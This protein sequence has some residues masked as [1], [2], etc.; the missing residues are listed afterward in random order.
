MPTAVVTGSY[1]LVGSYTA[2]Y[3]SEHGFNVIGIDADI[4]SSL[5]NDVPR[6]TAH[7]KKRI[8]DNKQVHTLEIDLRDFNL[9]ESQL[10]P[11]IDH[12]NGIDLFV[13]C[14][15]QPSHDWASTNPFADFTLNSSVTLNVCEFLRRHSSNSLLIHL[16]TNKVYGDTPNNLPLYEDI[17]RYELPSD[18]YFYNGVDES[19]SID[20]SLHSLFGVS[21][22]CADLYVQEYSRYFGMPALVLRGGCLTG[23]KHRGAKLHGFLNYLV[24]CAS[25][26]QTYTINGYKGKQVRDN[27]HATDIGRLVYVAYLKHVAPVTVNY[28]IVANLGGGRSNSISL[29]EAI[30]LLD[31]S[32]DLKLNYNIS[33]NNRVGDHI[34]YISD[35][36]QLTK[37]YDWRPKISINQIFEEII[38]DSR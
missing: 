36:S 13:H 38:N 4:R 7:E 32:F 9:L 24:K 28:P 11:L 16:S 37:N 19:M 12:Y 31:Q 5:F 1:G 14:A 20:N 6:L 23:A 35:Y 27:L 29:L 30:D 3:L 17:S 33:E 34:W 15:A 2:I 26:N 25:E 22:T 8:Y 18:H 10:V 21:K